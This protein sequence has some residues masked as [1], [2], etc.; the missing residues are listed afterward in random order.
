MGVSG[1]VQRDFNNACTNIDIFSKRRYAYQVAELFRREISHVGFFRESIVF[2]R[3]Q[4][5]LEGF[6]HLHEVAC[7]THT[8]THTH[9]YGDGATAVSATSTALSSHTKRLKA[10]TASF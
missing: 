3:N 1:E 10:H 4:Y 8:N 5:L 7:S 2:R 9:T 6:I